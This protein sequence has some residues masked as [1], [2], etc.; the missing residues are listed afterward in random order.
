[1]EQ[2]MQASSKR[3]KKKSGAMKL[4]WEDWAAKNPPADLTQYPR[5]E[6][7]DVGKF[8]AYPQPMQLKLREQLGKRPEDWNQPTTVNYDVGDA[9]YGLFQWKLHL[10]PKRILDDP[11]TEAKK[12]VD[13]LKNDIELNGVTLVLP[14]ATWMQVWQSN[15]KGKKRLI[16]VV[17]EPP[18][19]DEK[20]P[21]APPVIVKDEVP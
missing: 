17:M 3:K 1:M 12:T 2:A 9:S 11:T 8:T 6:Y 14:P 4:F 5:W 20:R 7:Y 18:E 15:E 19:L 21:E 10:F 13:T 16:R